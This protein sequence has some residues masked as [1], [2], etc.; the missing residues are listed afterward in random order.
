MGD[1]QQFFPSEHMTEQEDAKEQENE[2][3]MIYKFVCVHAHL[4][5]FGVLG[6]AD[7]VL[8]DCGKQTV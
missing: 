6:L 7:N 3:Y 5:M 4:Y 8:Y 2:G 1:W